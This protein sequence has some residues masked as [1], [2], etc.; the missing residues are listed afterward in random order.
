M[1]YNEMNQILAKLDQAVY[2]LEQAY[3][4]NGGE[5]TQETEQMEQEIACLQELLTTDGID[6][7][8]G[9]L[10]AKEDRK[11]ALKAEKD[12]ITRQ[13]SAIDE[14]IDYLKERINKVMASTGKDK[15]KGSRGYSFTA[16]TSTKTEVDK[17][18]LK[19]TYA[20]VIETAI[21]EKGV[22][23]YIGVTLTASSTKA[24]EI[25]LQDGDEQIFST[26]S[27]PSVRFAKPRAKED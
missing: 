6:L 4:D 7:L 26:S 25:G 14:T 11:K 16:I 8:G 17:E 24:A 9:W 27:K 13:M 3:I 23:E 22:P 12:Y 19:N 1:N 21:R 10:K 20:Q 2:N 18:I 15:I 5:C